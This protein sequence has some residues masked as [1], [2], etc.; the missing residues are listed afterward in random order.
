MSM[1]K[2]HPKC[3]FISRYFPPMFGGS[4]VYYR[5]LLSGCTADD[6]VVVA[7]PFEHPDTRSFDADAPYPIIRSRLIPSFRE[8]SRWHRLL[9]VLTM[10]PAMLFWV[11]RYRVSVLHLGDFNPEIIAGWLA[12]RLTGRRLMIT[13]LG[14]ELTTKGVGPW[15][16][17]RPLRMLGNRIARRLL[18]H[19]DLILT[20]SGFTKSE[21]LRHG[22]PENRIVTI[23]PGIDVNKS[24]RGRPIAAEIAARL[25]GRRILLTVGRFTPRKGQDMTI[26]A[27]PHVLARHPDAI[28]VMAGGGCYENYE[29]CAR[30]IDEFHLQNHAVLLKD[31]DNDS[32]AWL[33]ERCEIFIMANRTLA[34]GDTEGYGIVFLEA[35][36]WGKPVVGGRA[37]GVV[38]AV[39][40]GVTGILVD[41]ADEKCIA[42]ALNRLLS[43]RG[44]AE[45]LGKAGRRKAA[46][47]SWDA[48]SNEYRGLLEALAN[49]SK[50]Q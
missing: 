11:L 14:E 21:L 26:R 30:L 3:L 50:M 4:V 9:K 2:P 38:D 48:K 36:A 40:D 25:A 17:Y 42:D 47:N 5:Y 18:P 31:M 29:E 33:Y 49:A 12:A 10:F 35:G 27:M 46:E 15:S 8:S 22:V 39:D 44:L 34:N 6:V 23:T 16:I 24:R 13:I 37:G 20:I 1:T 41:G 7:A 45:R 43:D 32:V 28:Y 19:C